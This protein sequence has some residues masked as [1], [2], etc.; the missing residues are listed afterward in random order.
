MIGISI[1]AV[2]NSQQELKSEL[3]WQKIVQRAA[4]NFTTWK[5]GE[6]WEYYSNRYFT[7]KHF[8]ICNKKNFLGWELSGIRKYP[9]LTSLDQNSSRKKLVNKVGQHMC[10]CTASS[11]KA[12]ENPNCSPLPWMQ[13]LAKNCCSTYFRHCVTT[14]KASNPKHPAYNSEL[15]VRIKWN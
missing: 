14:L 4:E 11:Y 6:W 3:R 9:I 2:M 5:P 1:G 15:N 8:R 10:T 12:Y 7:V 13:L